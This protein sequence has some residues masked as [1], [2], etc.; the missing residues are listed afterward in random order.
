MHEQ[1]SNPDPGI[2][3]GTAP[4]SAPRPAAPAAAVTATAPAAPA[5]PAA[6]GAPT[7][8]PTAGPPP[9]PTGAP[10]DG[11]SPAPAGAPPLAPAAAPDGRVRRGGPVL[12]AAG[13]LLAALNLRIAIASVGPV[14]DGIEHGQPLSSTA[15]GALTTI[16]VLCFGGFAFATPAL[17]RRWGMH[18]LLGAT[19]LLLTAGV[20]VRLQPS[21]AALFTG[22]VVAGASIAVANVLMP[23]LIKHDFAHRSGLMMGLY[24][25]SLFVGAA[26]ASGLTVPLENALGTGW[27]HT[28]ALW[29]L[30]ALA[31]FLLWLPQTGSRRAAQ[32]ADHRL[33]PGGDAPGAGAT[34]RR[35]PGLRALVHDRTAWAV[36]VFMGT[37]SLGYYALLSWIPS[38]LQ[39]SGMSAGRSG[40][41]LSFS[42]FPGI[43]ASLLTPAL[44]RRPAGRAPAVV[45][46][47]VVCAVA[48]AG[49]ATAPVSLAYLWMTLL[50][51]G[52]GA[53]IS[54]ALSLIVWCT[55][56]AAHASAL[57]TLAQGTGYLVAALGPFGLGAVHSLTGGWT[58]PMLALGAVLAVQLAAGLL[59]SRE[60]TVGVRE[61]A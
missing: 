41:M 26:A 40:W 46:T 51:L 5:R 10:T 58:T 8:A 2:T 3:S 7:D 45:A 30:P 57:S 43:V 53:A 23:G 48:Y 9:A 21:T 38:L 60:H 6:T 22:T 25:T 19:M 28:L 4:G 29:A 11:P 18:R 44:G 14:L 13:L 52:Q 59:A 32:A 49:L 39:D 33:A 27:R 17:V 24:T 47:V 35:G 54:L 20:L 16:P 61:S 1:P 55:P 15:A 50:G 34:G 37:Q 31:A 56:D 12:L 42:T 36:T